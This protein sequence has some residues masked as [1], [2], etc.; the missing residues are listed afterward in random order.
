MPDKDTAHARSLWLWLDWWFEPRWR[1]LLTWLIL[2]MLDARIIQH[3]SYNRLERAVTW[4]IKAIND[5]IPISLLLGYTPILLSL[6]IALAMIWFE[7]LALRFNLWRGIAWLFLRA[8]PWV[9]ISRFSTNVWESLGVILFFDIAIIIIL[10][11]WRSRPWMI[12]ICWV[13]LVGAILWKKTTSMNT[14]YWVQS[15][16]LSACYALPMLYGTQ[17]L[18]VKRAQG[19]K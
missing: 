4:P 7:P 3:F 13:L 5:W 19:A 12:L 16:I 1:A 2:V 10:R 14:P 8:V 17:L 18:V 9:I 6:N 11:G 15:A